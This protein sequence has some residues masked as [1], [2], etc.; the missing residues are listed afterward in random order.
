MSKLKSGFTTG[1]CAA[2]AAKAAAMFLF[3]GTTLKEVEFIIPE[4]DRVVMPL[5]YV[6]GVRG[7]GNSAEAAVRKDAGDDPD[8]TNGVDVI[9]TVSRIDGNDV[10]IAAGEGVGIVSKPGLSVPPGEPAVNPVPRRMIRDAIREITESGVKVT[11]AIPGGREIAKKTFNP[12]LGI[13]GGLS[14][15]G[16]SGMVRPFSCSALRASLKCLLD[17]AVASG[18]TAPVFVPGHIG[19][20]AANRIFNLSAGQVIEIGNEWGYMLSAAAEKNLRALM[21]LGHP[22][23]LAKL[24][25]GEG[26]THSSRSKSAVPFVSRL[27]NDTVRRR[28]KRTPTVEGL[29]SALKED[30]RKKLGDLLAGKVRTAVRG[31]LGSNVATAVVLINM[32]GDILGE[33]GDLKR[34]KRNPAS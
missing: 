17:V 19:E 3:K 4:G 27:V 24:A 30:E 13:I 10:V 7:N 2:A 12:K 26:D 9:A 33:D 21:V 15:L 29:F 5:L 18:I 22:G 31:Y 34:W 8:V 11:I 14:I 6:C 23:K 16:T 25:M 1:T 20:R 32:Q 28:P